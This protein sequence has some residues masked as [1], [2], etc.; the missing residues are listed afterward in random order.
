MKKQA[1]LIISKHG[2]VYLPSFKRA[3]A[4]VIASILL[5]TAISGVVYYFLFR[6]GNIG[7]PSVDQDALEVFMDGDFYLATDV[8]ASGTNT[9]GTFSLKEYLGLAEADDITFTSNDS[10]IATISGDEITILQEG[11]LQIE[12]DN[13]TTGINETK[14]IF[15]VDGVN[16]T[17]FEE[18]FYAIELKIS[19]VLHNDITLLNPAEV[20][21]EIEA[22][23]DDDLYLYS[24]IYGNGFKIYCESLLTK[25]NGHNDAAFTLM[26]DNLII[27]DTHFIGLNLTAENTLVEL[28]VTGTIIKIESDDDF[29]VTGTLIEN[30][31]LENAH[32]LV[33]IRYTD[34]TI[35]GTILRNSSDANL[36]IRTTNMGTSNVTVE[37][38]VMANAVVASILFWCTENIQDEANFVTLNIVGFFDSYNWKNINNARIMPG[39]EPLEPIVSPIIQEYMHRPEYQSYYYDYNSEK[40][41]HLAILIISSPPSKGNIPT[42]NGLDN[43]NYEQRDFPFPNF[44]K[45]WI[46]TCDV[47]GY[48]QAPNIL[49]DARISDNENLYQELRNGRE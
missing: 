13:L 29:Y 8:F 3:L 6:G 17:N 27:R 39:T 30:C 34:L 24:N 10:S 21:Y 2:K 40:Y 23:N 20:D 41:I 26:A 7:S 44:A 9:S 15:I 31:I 19:I 11:D 47:A 18:L 16:V 32:T 28:E 48:V 43:I 4:M 49:P 12:I 22:S 14:T 5:L 42:I 36:S 37:N 1:N 35:K 46:A 45:N 38:C 33:K 25:T